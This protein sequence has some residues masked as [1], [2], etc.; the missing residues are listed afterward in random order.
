[1][2]QERQGAPPPSQALDRQSGRRGGSK[3]PFVAV[4]VD[5]AMVKSADWD[6]VFVGDLPSDGARLGETDVVRFAR[7]PAADNAGLRRHIPAVE[8]VT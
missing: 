6:G 5:F 3:K 7:N 4:S 8:L 2:R 1:M